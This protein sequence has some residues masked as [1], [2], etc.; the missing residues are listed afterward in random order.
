LFGLARRVYFVSPAQQR[1]Y[2]QGRGFPINPDKILLCPAP[3]DVDKFA[4]SAQKSGAVYVGKL[5]RDKGFDNLVAYAR[6]TGISLELYGRKEPGIE[7]PPLPNLQYKGKVPYE[8]VPGIL[9]RAQIA[10]H[11]PN[12]LE[13]YGRNVMEA[14]LSGCELVINGNVGAMSYDWDWSDRDAVRE[15]VRRAPNDFWES[16]EAV[17]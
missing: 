15:K 16:I 4:P 2:T 3:I 7:I 13:C 11:L 6:K 9:A 17:V 14:Y 10:V 12:W 5:G 8:Q 1:L